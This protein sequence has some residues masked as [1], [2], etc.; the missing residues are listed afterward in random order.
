[1]TATI[2]RCDEF[3][4]WAFDYWGEDA[5]K[6]W[7]NEAPPKP[8][9]PTIRGT[10]GFPMVD[11]R[12]FPN[13]CIVSNRTTGYGSWDKAIASG[14]DYLVGER[15][16]TAKFLATHRS[17]LKGWQQAAYQWTKDHPYFQLVY[18]TPGRDWEV[19][20][21]GEYVTFALPH[22]DAGGERHYVSR[23]VKT[24]ILVNVD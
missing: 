17:P 5:K 19:Y 16:D 23:D 12:V 24:K 2:R 9:P 15:V 18:S 11:V 21:S 1:M 20:S 7:L 6:A 4:S 10:H 13:R 8:E 22:Q 3:E 14:K